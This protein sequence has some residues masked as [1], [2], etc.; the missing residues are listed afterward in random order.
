MRAISYSRFS[1]AE[2][3]LGHS[4]KRQLEAARSYCLRNGLELDENLSISD[5]GLS[6]YKG[7]NVERG[8][9]GHF[10]AEVKAGKIPAGTALII[11][12][13]DRLSRQGIDATVDLL[14][15]LTACGIDVHVIAH[16]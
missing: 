4:T 11:E 14:K 12:N 5:E 6:G 7:H 13:L 2:Q 8:S 3:S 16:C 1:N 10:L 9:L 15:Q